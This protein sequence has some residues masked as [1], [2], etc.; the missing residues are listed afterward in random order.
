MAQSFFPREPTSRPSTPASS[1]STFF[2]PPDDPIADALGK[3]VAGAE[4]A[5][6][7]LEL[8]TKTGLS[9]DTIR[10]NREAIE[11]ELT[12]Y[13][14]DTDTFRRRSPRLA[15]WLA[16]DKLR[17]A[18]AQDDLANLQRLEE[19][20]T[21]GASIL[22]GVD[23]VQ[24]M[25]GGFLEASGELVGAD[26]LAAYGR[27][28]RVHNRDQAQALGHRTSVFELRGP[29]DLA[30]WV[31][32]TVGEQI[33]IMAPIMVAGVAGGQAGAIAGTAVFPG[34]GT[35]VGLTVGAA[36]GAFIPAFMMGVGEVQ[37]TIKDID[38]TASAPA[39]AFLGGSAVA[40]LDTVL[41]AK[42]G[43]SLV[44]TFGRETAEE[45]AKR[46]L[47]AP[48]K[49][50]WLRSTLGGTV[51]GMASEG[52]T[53]AVQ[54]AIGAIAGATGT[55]T[56][57]PGDLWQQMVEAGAAGAL[58]GGGSEA[59]VEAASHRRRVAQFAA[60]QQQKAFFDTL[61]SGV[62]DSKLMARLP[63]AAAEFL[64]RATKD[65]PLEH[66]YA[67]ADT[68][69]E[70]WQQQGVNPDVMAE[71][72]TGRKGALE[73]ARAAGTDL[74]IA[75]ATYATKLAATEHHAFF[76]E[77]LR[78][79][80][81][82]LN[83]REVKALE[84]ETAAG[85]TPDARQSAVHEQRQQV[86]QRVLEQALAAGARPEVAEAW[87][88]LQAD[89]FVTRAQRLGINPVK[90]L[91]LRPPASIVSD[92]PA[93]AAVSAAPDG[94]T[95][96]SEGN[97]RPAAI[98][99]SAASAKE[100][101]EQRATRRQA[102]LGALT[103][104]VLRAARAIDPTVDEGVIREELELRV[105]LEEERQAAQRESGTGQD[106]L[107]AIASYGGLWWEKNTGAYKGEIEHY[108]ESGRDVAGVKAGSG[109]VVHHRGRAT[110]N[111]LAGVF[112]EDGL[113]PDGMVE[114]LR[115][116]PR[117]EY[118]GDINDLLDAVDD[119]MRA[120]RDVDVLPGTEDLARLGIRTGEAWWGDSWAAPTEDVDETMPEDG[121]DD[122]FDPLEFAQ[123]HVGPA[124]AN[125]EAAYFLGW[126]E[127][128][129]L[130]NP[131]LPLFNVLGGPRD[132]STVTL[133]SLEAMEI[134]IPPYPAYESNAEL[135]QQDVPPAAGSGVDAAEF[136]P[137]STST[138]ES[139][140]QVFDD[141]GRPLLGPGGFVGGDQS[142]LQL[143]PESQ[144]LLARHE[145]ILEARKFL[146]QAAPLPSASQPRGGGEELLQALDRKNTPP[147]FDVIAPHLTPEE[148]Q[149]LRR[150]TAQRLVDLYESLP[151]DK[152]FA[153]AAVAGGAKKGWYER[154]TQAI[155]AVFGP[156][157]SLR[158]TALL[159]AL[160]PQTSVESNLLNTVRM[161]R[162]WTEA[163][164]PTSR[165]EIVAL[166]ARSVRGTQGADSVL[167]S[168]INNTV[169]ALTT[170]DP[171][172][173]VLSGPKVQSFT[174]NLWG[175]LQEVT[176]DAWMANFA[177]IEQAV[178]GGDINK[179]GTDPGKGPG[180][181]AMSAKIRRVA[182]LLTKQ[183]G[184]EWTPAH[185]QETVWSW[186]KTLY[187]LAEA[188]DDTAVEVL[189]SGRLGDA[190]IAQ[191]V[192]FAGLF[193]KDVD[194]R[195]ILEAAGYGKV[196]D[197][198]EE[199]F[200][201]R[202]GVDHGHPRAGRAGAR[203]ADRRVTPGLLRSARR[204]DE[205]RRRRAEE[206][207]A[208][209]AEK[210]KAARAYAAAKA[211][212]ARALARAE[213]ARTRFE[214]LEREEL[215][216]RTGDY[217]QL[218]QTYDRTDLFGHK[219]Q[220]L[221]KAPG[222]YAS[223][224]ELVVVSHRQLG[225]SVIEHHADAA[226]AAAYL[227][228][229]A[230][231]RF[232]AIVTDAAGVP[233]AVVGGFK[234]AVNQAMVHADV[235]LAEAVRI[236][237]A[238]AIWFAHNHPSG[239]PTLSS[240]DRAINTMLVERFR[241]S[242]ITARGTLAIGNGRYQFVG[243]GG[244]HVDGAVGGDVEDGVE[245][246]VV[247]REFVATEKMG[248]PITSPMQ[249]A[250]EVPGLAGGDFGVVL[251][252]TKNQPIAFLP[253]VPKEANALRQKKGRLAELYR[254]LSL[255]GAAAAI[256]HASSLTNFYAAVNVARALN[257]RDVSVLD[258][259]TSDVNGI[260]QSEKL[261]NA[262]A[263][264]I[265]GE[266]LQE[267]DAFYDWF[268]DSQ[269]VDSGGKP[270]VV[271]HGTGVAFDVFDG[272]ESVGWFAEEPALAEPYAEGGSA[273]AARNGDAAAVGPH[274]VP[275]FLSIQNPLN[276]EGATGDRHFDM[277]DDMTFA[278]LEAG[279]PELDL[280]AMEADYREFRGHAWE[281][282]NTAL[283]MSALR[284]AGYDGIKV[285]ERGTMTWGVVDQTQIKSAIGNSGAFSRSNP[286]ILR[287]GDDRVKGGY[288]PSTNVIRLVSGKAD[289]STFLHESGH[290]FLE[291]LM[292]DA[293][294]LLPEHERELTREQQQ[295]LSDIDRVLNWFGFSGTH[296][297][298]LQ[299]SVDARRVHHEQFA[300]GFEA[301]LMEGRAPS[302][303]LR[304]A[305]ARFRAWLVA[306]YRQ[307]RALRVDVTPEIRGVFDR[308]LATDDAI[309][310]AEAEANVTPLFT[311][312]AS[313]GVDDL[314]FAAY[315]AT[316]EEAARAAR[317]D[318]DRKVM[319]EWRREQQAWWQN[320]RD[321]VRAAVVT[322]LQRQPAFVAQT[323]IRAGK[324][325]D[326][327]IPQFADGRPL[328]LSKTDIV[329]QFGQERLRRLPRPYL[330][331][332]EGGI[333]VD[334]AA[335]LF[336]F[337]SGDAL[338]AALERTPPIQ[339]VIDSETDLRMRE[340]HGD[341]LLEGVSLQELAEHAVHEH[342]AQ[343][344]A[345]ELRAL[346]RGMAQA[347]IP[348]TELL[349]AAAE[350]RIRGTKLRELK[351]GLFLQAS[352]RAAREAF[353]AFGRNDRAGAIR[354]KQ[355]ELTALELYRAAA[356]AQERA[357]SRRRELVKFDT[358]QPTR[359]RLGRA[360]QDY[361][362]QVDAV[363]ERYELKRVT[364]TQL[365]RRESL[366]K[367][368]AKLEKQGLPVDIPAEVLDDAR[369]VNWQELTVEELEGVY[370]AVA[371][372]AHLAR[373]K[374][375]LLKA[376]RQ[377]E[378]AE[379]TAELA[380]SIRDHGTKREHGQE[381]RLPSQALAKLREGVS[382][383]HRKI[384]SLAR[385]LDGFVDG[386]PMWEYIIRPL[387]E[388]ADREA[389]VNADAMTR[390]RALFDKYSPAERAQWY[391]LEHIPALGAPTNKNAQLSKAGKLMVAL[392]WGNETNRQRL[393]DGRGWTDAQ[394]QAV[395]D[396]LDKRDW[397]LV[398]GVWDFLESYWPEI[399]EKQR[400]VVGVAPLKV[401]ATPVFTRFGEFRGGY[402]PLKYEGELAP[403]PAAHAEAELASLQQ[404]AAYA[405]AQTRRGHTKERAEGEVKLPVRLDFG[406]LTEHLGQVIH[407]LTH[408]EALV[409]VGRILRDEG[410]AAAIYDVAGDQVYRQ[411]KDTLRDVAVG[412]VPARHAVEKI[413]THLRN[414]ATVVGMGWSFT[415][416]IMQFLG[417]TQSVVRIGPE[418]VA[419]GLSSWLGSPRRMT[420]KVAWIHEQSTFMQ[421]RAATINREINE[422]RN[423]VGLDQGR[424]LGWI[425]QV[426]RQ[427][428]FDAVTRHAIAD[429]YFSMIGKAQ[430]MV[431]VPTWLG[432]YE[433]A[434]ADP[435][436]VLE[437]GTI[438]EKRVVALADQAVKDSQGSGQIMDLAAVQRGSAYAKLFTNFYS[439]F[440]VT[441][442]LAAE[443]T[444]EAKRAPRSP[445]A[446]ARL[447]SD[448]LLLFI[449]PGA[450]GSI[451]R[452]AL[453]GEDEPEEYAKNA[454]LSTVAYVLG[455]MV[456]LRELGSA[457][458]GFTDYDGPA[459][460]RSIGSMSTFVKA[461]YQGK[462]TEETVRAG[463][464]AVGAIFHLPTAQVRR[465]VEGAI[466][467]IEGRTQ[468]PAA[469]LV[470]APRE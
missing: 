152:D 246:P 462:L 136:G 141:N 175:H 290:Q 224:T 293:M 116:D 306:I 446:V 315:R 13:G 343:V 155:R 358:H 63:Q 325:P 154:S 373:L 79:A 409:D 457:V 341:L 10:R 49:P 25:V 124:N 447:A 96:E 397:E 1:S 41:P 186:A 161:W 319:A 277:D 403:S 53:E 51:S 244:V 212:A 393:R 35:A 255:S 89:R 198:L 453:K 424:V 365:D 172:R 203:Q 351:P 411:F 240:D 274:L 123:R 107:R 434:M 301:Y 337:G 230:Q 398:Q 349:R 215:E 357:Q 24:G 149:K 106:L 205:L 15:E 248:P 2:P 94:N 181:L 387:N 148:K 440:N 355:A 280:S 120:D 262:G 241:D 66:V 392:N 226:A 271:Y 58:V 112:R 281:F 76:A 363:L 459:G 7:L 14:F 61:A 190:A 183:T 322:E 126:Q 470:G 229:G 276:I 390:L 21:F 340:K 23:Q 269:V 110:Y 431:D 117:F 128:G 231:E 133:A 159:A 314:T 4:E 361:V 17:V 257:A 350:A 191:T 142:A 451:I 67:P 50:S 323:V 54:E 77:E 178:L 143:G 400:R 57:L 331:T 206:K 384:A 6:K 235:I 189:R 43:S 456:L 253:L 36:I 163:G 84:A 347:A 91:E 346:T 99:R 317:E 19:T 452:D 199:A 234:G 436:N 345:A 378:F 187:E 364:A 321:I 439:V 86:R 100:T 375:R 18:A 102:H 458:Q 249:A 125:G 273:I 327:S 303:E 210:L 95:R 369:Q 467:L 28:V 92:L 153:E 83:A 443:R 372:I 468:N 137:A 386:G 200:D 404:Q 450:I 422:L 279:F 232:D 454:A 59:V 129:D 31:K 455:T 254:G 78:L 160:S 396:T 348:R 121:G 144:R 70:Y 295:L 173:I 33:P 309:A 432:A 376:Q 118:I 97:S 359:A 250:A 88:T 305:F 418:W 37:G 170:E 98:P 261:R 388:A 216:Q 408:H 448:Y 300:R 233:L 298:W 115:Q 140:Q 335:E 64:Q 239:D 227:A 194:V 47:L 263:M 251:L 294:L 164:R 245:V 445:H 379:V 8:R 334:V 45:V 426:L 313:A 285:R 111:G 304:T 146:S 265:G 16:E 243:A 438:D 264:Q 82:A 46:A 352:R 135:R 412:D 441:Y 52:L 138:V 272:L 114:A 222:R 382:A 401:D 444:R 48:L 11:G 258:I 333:P 299:L 168:W 207:A 72:L 196:L 289:L 204:L 65:G 374:N 147:G 425:D 332:V 266:F 219:L 166:L 286:S 165:E 40:A 119:A 420:Q 428:S 42:L 413:V 221:D 75:T 296:Q 449:I 101:S 427:A 56:A 26:G 316:I 39:A 287:Q 414:G 34:V 197:A 256:V 330:Y 238:A 283:F 292:H 167:D 339:Q 202:P 370:E 284:D 105:S 389:A 336:G 5:S 342:R 356:A 367:F 469:L 20:L 394:V 395:L 151:S 383:S 69:A 104:S 44:R 131:A 288:N 461:A 423:V 236:K 385:E 465:S 213:Q 270:R 417:L 201:R 368:V 225:A 407:D 74:V 176:N 308:L 344:I 242:G 109:R 180:Y 377:R 158:F 179:A 156:V 415:T 157:E 302:P 252:D 214:R 399:A 87:A 362:D 211:K 421:H 62:T 80:P 366:R 328:K 324:L 113:T 463:S 132:R 169:R 268:G 312:A 145:Q 318:V 371:Q 442:N 122:S 220:T 182:K 177:L 22:R 27:E 353:E 3:P 410:V 416:P 188:E 354:A 85:A 130:A 310:A 435:A 185:V 278:R 275:V 247:E 171:M 460:L 208:K 430:L 259:I 419:R 32:E 429:S 338:L 55:G 282:V 193:T 297:E 192:D 360:G 68:F 162:N 71:E 381:T 406:V 38:P 12:R 90:L 391:R 134:P 291:E 329:A 217:H 464:E 103:S 402:F 30:Q 60:A 81:E 380:T 73:E 108:L 209:A 320:E 139:D 127:T 195:S 93:A 223:R 174:R 267:T 237:G 326:G 405:G 29:W 9:P 150:D 184:E 437:D 228:R 311:D 307:A 260:G 433:K 218:A 466:A